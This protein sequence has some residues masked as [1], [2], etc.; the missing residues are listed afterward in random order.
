M[1]SGSRR[2]LGATMVYGAGEA[3]SRF[4][5]L[6]LLPLFTAYLSPSEYGVIAI[7]AII[8]FLVRPVFSLGL[9]TAMGVAYFGRPDREYR[10]GVV[11]TAL[12][13]LVT[14]SALMLVGGIGAA[15][16]VSVVSLGSAAFT[17]LVVLTLL[18]A[19]AVML[20]QPLLQELQF[21]GRARLYVTLNTAGT[22]ASIGLAILFVVVLRRGVRG[23]VEADVIARAI[24]LALFA[25]PAL[26][27]RRPQFRRDIA[28]EL[29]R[30]GLPMVPGFAFAFV[31]QQGNKYILQ[32]LSGLSAVGLYNVGFS[33]GMAGLGM[34]VAAFQRAWTPHFMDYIG[35]RDEARVAFGRIMTHYVFGFGLLSLMAFIGARAIVLVLTQPAFHSAYRTLGLG[36]AAQFLFGGFLILLPGPYF[37]R[38]VKSTM[39]MQGLAAAVAVAANLLLIPMFGI[40]GAGLGMVTGALAQIAFQH[41]RNRTRQYLDVRYDWP[42]I[43]RFAMLYVAIAA[44]SLVQRSFPLWLE[45]TLDVLVAI[46]VTLMAFALLDGDDRARVRSLLRDTLRRG[47]PAAA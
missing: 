37:E 7:L 32:W 22:L 19:A 25:G 16:R 2:L 26:L 27:A 11:W 29:I 13:I 12:A 3:L 28:R 45:L 46:A 24:V 35:R 21:E 41:W 44:A 30:L 40:V 6:L 9:E 33:I 38:D 8:P 17:P 36:A 4:I 15:S 43:G 23:W 47:P 1:A 18:S 20:T 39:L 34:P 5:N 14:T 31:L 10:S 42:R